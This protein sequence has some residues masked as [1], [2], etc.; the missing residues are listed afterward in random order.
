MD[1][2]GPTFAEPHGAA[3]VFQPVAGSNASMP[4]PGIGAIHE[5]ANVVSP[6][7]SDPVADVLN[8]PH[9]GAA[10]AVFDTAAGDSAKATI[11]SK[12]AIPAHFTIGL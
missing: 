6:A 7:I 5:P 1:G 3:F 9:G 10:P 2:I 4:I 12:P 8:G 11:L